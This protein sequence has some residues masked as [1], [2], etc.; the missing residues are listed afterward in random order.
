MAIARTGEPLKSQ[1]VSQG[2]RDRVTSLLEASDVCLERLEQHSAG[3][4]LRRF[5]VEVSLVHQGGASREDRIPQ[6]R[7]CDAGPWVAPSPRRSVNRELLRH[8]ATSQPSGKSPL[9][10]APPARCLLETTH[11][12]QTRSANRRNLSPSR[13]GEPE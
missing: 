8:V 13:S 4:Q 11:P 3:G 6:A 12:I 7:R 5:V 2:V 10:E 1:F 9:V